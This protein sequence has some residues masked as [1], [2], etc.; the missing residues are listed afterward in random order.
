MA[1]LL[2]PAAF[3]LVKKPGGSPVPETQHDLLLL[4]LAK[5]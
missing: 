4:L 2:K 1:C 5:H 3:N